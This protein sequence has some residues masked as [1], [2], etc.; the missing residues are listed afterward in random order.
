MK[1]PAMHLGSIVLSIIAMTAC[2][3]RPQKAEFLPK[4]KVIP[5]VVVVDKATAD[6]RKGEA[7]AKKSVNTEKEELP[8]SLVVGKG[9]DMRFLDGKALT[10]YYSHIFPKRGY[11]YEHCANRLPDEASGCDDSIFEIAEG[12]AMGSFGIN[13]RSN[14]GTQNV[15]APHNLTLNY[16]RTLRAALSRECSYLVRTER[17]KLKANSGLANTLVKAMAPAAADL[18]EFFRTIVG[19]KGT[20]IKVEIGSADYVTAF[21]EI[22]GAASTA[23]KERAA[24]EAYL[25]LCI[26]VSMNPQVIIY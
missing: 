15:K 9:T 23:T 17:A 26:A 1:I 8:L 7:D 18:D 24:D 25:G 13:L 12:S 4:G 10:A 20:G 19:L 21:N 5:E 14:R 22:V 2:D 11:G 3:G 6:V 16:M